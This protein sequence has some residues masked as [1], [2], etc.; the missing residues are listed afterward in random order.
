MKITIKKNKTEIKIDRED[1]PVVTVAL[2]GIAK[3]QEATMKPSE[4]DD[5]DVEELL[6]K[7]KEA[8]RKMTFFNPWKFR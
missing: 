5:I 8:A 1:I 6:N 2:M 3:E 4:T 7:A